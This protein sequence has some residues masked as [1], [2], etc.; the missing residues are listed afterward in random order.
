MCSEH[1]GWVLLIGLEL[2]Q[3]DVDLAFFNL[4]LLTDP[5][6][7]PGRSF[8]WQRQSCKV[9]DEATQ[10]IEDEVLICLNVL[11]E[12]LFLGLDEPFENLGSSLEDVVVAFGVKS[13]LEEVSGCILLV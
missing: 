7:C 8:I 6:Q 3:E 1:L 2:C 13:L 12:L 11:L 9:G 5:K 4:I 10:L